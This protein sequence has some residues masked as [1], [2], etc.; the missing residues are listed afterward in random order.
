MPW[1]YVIDQERDAVLVTATGVV[2]GEE[3]T[4]GVKTLVQDPGFHPDI[5]MLLDYHAISELRVSYN[6]IETLASSRVYSAKSRRACYVQVGFALGV[7][8]Y[9][10]AF[11]QAGRVEVFTDRAEALAW[12]NESVPPEKA[13]V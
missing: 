10:Q 13:L 9:Y 8:Q 3:L 5:R 11:A 7:G 1:N 2:T 4:A 6:V 12:L